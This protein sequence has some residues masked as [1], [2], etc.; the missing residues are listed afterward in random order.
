MGTV[1][2]VEHHSRRRRQFVRF[3]WHF[4]LVVAAAAMGAGVWLM[5]IAWQ[6]ASQPLGML[7][8]TLLLSAPML[9]VA[10]F[11]AR[12]INSS[13]P[14]NPLASDWVDAIHRVDDSLRIVR[15]CRA[16]IGVAGSFVLVLWYCQLTGY[17]ALM[18]FLVFYTA[19][20]AVAAVACL[21]WLAA[22][23]HRLYDDRAEYRRLLGEAEAAPCR[24]SGT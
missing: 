17:V 22:R 20:C 7:S 21:P 14:E 6:L 19:A 13:G 15:L 24:G 3:A 8:V 23:E 16:H 11:L 9:A 10:V 5:F 2:V 18:E 1:W 12:P 4:A